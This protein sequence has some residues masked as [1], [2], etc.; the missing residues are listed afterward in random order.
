MRT[1]PVRPPGLLQGDAQVEERCQDKRALLHGLRLL[2]AEEWA[3]T[4]PHQVQPEERDF[5]KASRDQLDR[6]ARP[7]VWSAGSLGLSLS[8]LFS[9]SSTSSSN[10]LSPLSKCNN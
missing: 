4:H 6:E 8:F 5:V 10:G 2:E 3:K 9:Q 1:R 7:G